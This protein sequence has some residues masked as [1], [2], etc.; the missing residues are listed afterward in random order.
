L[1]A[2]AYK[3]GMIDSTVTSATYTINSGAPV[4]LSQGQPV[5]ASSFQTG[6]DP[7]L[8]NDGSLTTRWGAS[9]PGY[10]QWWRVD[11]GANHNLSQVVINWYD[12]STRSYQYR[13]EVSTDDVNYTTVI[14]QTGRTA[15]GDTT[16]NFTATV[17]FASP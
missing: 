1:K 10:P 16:D 12:A 13:I 6:N 9:G 2:I 14:D 3:S 15:T 7:S 11:L 4:L 8:G 17:M 5:T